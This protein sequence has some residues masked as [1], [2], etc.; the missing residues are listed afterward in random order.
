MTSEQPGMADDHSTPSSTQAAI[1]LERQ[2]YRFACFAGLAVIPAL[3]G[4]V[5]AALAL[6]IGL[7]L[8]D[9]AVCRNYAKVAN[10]LGLTEPFASLLAKVFAIQTTTIVVILV[11]AYGLLEL[12]F[13]W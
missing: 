7:T 10:T 4:G 13:T 3:C 9:I 2:E 6:L 5:P 8:F 1:D 11:F 12:I